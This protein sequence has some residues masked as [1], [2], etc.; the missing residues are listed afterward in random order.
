MIVVVLCAGRGSRLGKKTSNIPKCM[1]KLK[2]KPLIYWSQKF[3]NNFKK[4]IFVCGYKKDMIIKNFNKDPKNIFVINNEFKST[5]M[6][7]S[8]FKI[9]K[10]HIKNEDIVVC[11]SD[12]I[13]NPKIFQLFK[14]KE[15]FIPIKLDW[16]KLWKK[17]MNLKKIKKDAE[18]IQISG[19]NIES[20]G[21]KLNKKLPDYQFM[22][23]VKIKNNDFFKLKS[24]FK[25]LNKRIDFTTFL[26]EAISN[27]I[28][29]LR[30]KKTKIEWYEIDNQKD[31]K[32]TESVRIRW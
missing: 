9:N 22:G 5:N 25:K 18:N 17:R 10:R 21:G 29:K 2:N 26:N 3:R 30:F 15:T 16:L 31:L 4:N 20:I 1:V 6:V 14:T 24:F 32:Y 13:F 19:K 7:Y 12:I 27:Q 8:L 11:Y 28:I 23:L